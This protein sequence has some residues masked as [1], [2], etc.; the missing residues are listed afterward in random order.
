MQSQ[1]IK[2]EKV[3][4]HTPDLAKEKKKQL[5]VTFYIGGKQ[6]EKLTT[7]QSERIADRLSKTMNLYYN[8]HL[9]EFKKIAK[10]K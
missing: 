6:V 1:E 4:V 2:N 8:S 9:L 3:K 10:E 5:T 7:E